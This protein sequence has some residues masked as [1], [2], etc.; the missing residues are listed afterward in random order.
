MFNININV[1]LSL[2]IQEAPAGRESAGGAGPG[3][4]ALVLRTE[5]SG[6]HRHSSSSS[7]L[8]R[9]QHARCREHVTRGDVG[10]KAGKMKSRRI[11]LRFF[12]YCAIGS[13]A[14]DNRDDEGKF[15]VV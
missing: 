10:R 8:Y 6:G 12:I 11:L 3:A 1:L 15:S 13:K 5:G 4:S 2:T 14:G 9:K 7:S